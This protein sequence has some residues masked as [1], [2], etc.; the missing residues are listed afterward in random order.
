[1]FLKKKMDVALIDEYIPS[2]KWSIG[3]IPEVVQN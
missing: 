3:T 2:S 1:M